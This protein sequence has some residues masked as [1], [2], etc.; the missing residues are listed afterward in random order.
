MKTKSIILVIFLFILYFI[1]NSFSY[2]TAISSNIQK[3]IFR[4]H[5]IAN[6][7]S[8]EDQNLKL[9]IR[10]EIVKYLSSFS[11][12]NKD[13]IISFLQS[14]ENEI[15][16][17]TKHIIEEN[18]FNYDCTIEIGNSYY[19]QKKYKNIILPSGTYD[20]LKIKLGE[21]KGHNWWCVLFPPMCMIDSLTCEL[22]EESEEIL[23]S[24]VSTETFNIITSD[25]PQYKFKFKIIDLINDLSLK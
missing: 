9:V 8:P 11:F 10:D 3:E 14:H 21:S 18:H 25:L 24:S 23:G 13:E 5:I 16:E 2:T 7:N 4:L 22:P 1:F 6:S 17:L 12:N 20:G 15:Y 19:P